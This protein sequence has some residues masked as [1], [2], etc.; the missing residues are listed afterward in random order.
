MEN[1]AIKAELSNPDGKVETI[2]L[3]LKEH[4]LNEI[5]NAVV[6]IQANINA[7]L[8]EKIESTKSK[9]PAQ[10]KPKKG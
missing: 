9:E 6:E 4:S 2:S 7:V 5:K 3:N 8:T 10:K 1:C